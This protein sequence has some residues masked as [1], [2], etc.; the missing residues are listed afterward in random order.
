M[1]SFN[2]DFSNIDLFDCSDLDDLIAPDPGART[3]S[4]L[5][6]EQYNEEDIFK[7]L[8]EY[9]IFLFVVNISFIFSFSSYFIF[10]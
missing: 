9:G 5:F 8:E 10:L 6:L 7:F 4:N 3:V 2:G 1:L